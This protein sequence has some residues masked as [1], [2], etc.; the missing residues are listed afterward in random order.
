METVRQKRRKT[1]PREFWMKH[2]KK[3]SESG[4]TQKEYCRQNGVG[5][6]SMGYWKR[7]LKKESQEVSFVHLPIPFQPAPIRSEALRL[8][9]GD[10]YKIEVGNH[11][12]A[13]TLKRLIQTI[14]R[15]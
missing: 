14:E 6:K 7:K 9:C 11:F 3:C 12:S 13:D 10:K 5:L 4:L 1:M 15:L 8:I 2:I